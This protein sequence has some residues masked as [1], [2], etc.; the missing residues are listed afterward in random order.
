MGRI[1]DFFARTTSPRAASVK[2]PRIS[3]PISPQFTVTHKAGKRGAYHRRIIRHD[4]MPP[5]YIQVGNTSDGRPIMQAFARHVFLHATKGLRNY[6]R[7]MPS[8][9]QQ[10]RP[11]EAV[12]RQGK[13]WQLWRV[14]TIGEG[15]RIIAPFQGATA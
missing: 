1:K 11:D 4:A 13:G 8:H 6:A 12:L 3:A 9:N 2:L 10:R 14:A 7:G 5:T 15:G